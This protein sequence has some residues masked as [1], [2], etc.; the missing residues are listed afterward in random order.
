MSACVGCLAAQ[1]LS[2]FPLLD[3]GFPL[4]DSRVLCDHIE[5]KDA[6]YNIEWS[7]H[8]SDLSA[9]TSE[10]HRPRY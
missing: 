1:G 8:G 7:D 9:Q 6:P 2:E 3:F 5:R 4:A 10:I